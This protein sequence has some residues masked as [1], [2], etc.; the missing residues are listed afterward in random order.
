MKNSIKVTDYIFKKIQEEGVD[1]VPIY[2][3]GN[4]LHLINAVGQNKK[5][6]D[7]VNY[8]E[9]ANG[10]A[11]E[12]Y[13]RFKPLGVCCVGSGPAATNLSSAVM[14][15]YCDSIPS[16][17]VTGQV[18]MFHNKQQRKIRQRG[19]QEVDVAGHMKPITKYSVLVTKLENIRY[20]IEK[21]IYLAKSGRP[22]PVVMDVPY[23]V[24]VAQ[25][26]PNKL[27]R[28]I[29]PKKI[30]K[31]K[32]YED[33]SRSL[34]SEIKKSKKPLIILG[35]GVQNLKNNNLILKLLTKLN[36][37]VATTW[38]ATDVLY[39]D[40]PLN[41]GNAGRSGN[42]SAVYAIQESDLLISF[43]CRFTTKVVTN[44]K[45][46]A[47]NAKKI[48][49]D[50]DKFEFLQGL[51]KFD[52]GYEVDLKEFIPILNK[53]INEVNFTKKHDLSWSKRINDLKKNQYL[54]DETIT[55]KNKKYISPFKFMSN[56]F[57]QAKKNAV[58]IPDA[59]MNITWTYQANRLKKGQRL[60]TGAGAS[61]MGYALP[62]AIGAYFATKSDQTIVIAGDGGFQMNI[63]ELQ[64][65]AFHK[66]PIKIIIL[67]NES[68]GNTRFP[69][70][71]MFGN[72]TGNDVKGGY[73]WPD[74][75]KVAKAYGIEAMNIKNTSNFKPQID[76]IL[77]SKK[78]ILVDVRIDPKQFM[79]DTPI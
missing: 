62:A 9:Q 12:A 50:I 29:P 47:S 6:N 65:I 27:K 38:A 22:G 13:G 42:R 72:S 78:P 64:A 61:P 57:M 20:E 67:N 10:L 51:I 18:G 75:I 73:G 77:R 48:N 31:T 43:G 46:F 14:S 2:Q 59:G 45:T 11:A 60:F 44:E 79:L 68:L 56:L 25:I 34:I 26:I 39:Y 19:F 37:P 54:I 52:K 66:L 30:K 49:F 58:F 32:K 70:Q 76:K 35:G 17:F 53:Y 7:F 63:Q 36:I 40:F 28:F 1:F 24:Q 15:A 23:N 71:K 69:A 4:A 5:L 3:S 33:I 74:F 8:H 55:S 41:L 16:L 21:C